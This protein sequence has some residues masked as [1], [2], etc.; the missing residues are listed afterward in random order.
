[1]SRYSFKT[2]APKQD[3][4][5]LKYFD[6]RN[7]MGQVIFMISK[8]ETDTVTARCDPCLSFSLTYENCSMT[9]HLL[10]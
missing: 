7:Q 3:L 8:T 1:M 5:Q 2:V 9:S 4:A 10:R 6:A